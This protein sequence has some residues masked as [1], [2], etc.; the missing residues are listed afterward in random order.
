MVLMKNVEIS[1]ED[2]LCLSLVLLQSDGLTQW[3]LS[4]WQKGIMET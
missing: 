3:S 4:R 1:F 2:E